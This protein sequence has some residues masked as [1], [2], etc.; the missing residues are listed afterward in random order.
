MS[1]DF[2][3]LKE[4]LVAWP[5]APVE[6]VPVNGVY[7]RIFQIL[8]ASREC[9]FLKERSDLLPLLRQAMLEHRSSLGCETSII[10]LRVP[11]GCGWPGEACWHDFGFYCE[12]SGANCCTVTA[13]RW[14]PGWLPHADQF[15]P[16]EEIYA[17]KQCCPPLSVPIDPCVKDATGFDSYSSAGQREAVR[18]TFFAPAGST[19]VVNL[20]T[21]SGKSLVGYLPSLLGGGEGNFTLFVVPTVA[22]AIDQAQKLRDMYQRTGSSHSGTPLAWYSGVPE[23]DKILI[24]NNIKNGVQ[25]ILFT[26]PE[27]VCGAL[28]WALYE[29]ARR[30]FLKCLVVDE[31]HLVSQWGI[32]FRPDFQALSGIWRGLLDASE[33]NLKTLLMTATLTDETLDT[34]ETLF[35]S[36]E[37]SFQV[38]SAVY[39]RPE[40]RY[41]HY[42]ALSLAEKKGCVLEAVRKGPR[43]LILYVT[44]PKEADEWCGDL[45]REGFSR[46]AS[47]HGNT[48]NKRRIE[49]INQ[50]NTNQLDLIV[51]TSAFGVGMD[52]GDVRMILHAT[53]PENLDRYYQ[54]VGRG[55]RD[56]KAS[57]SLLIYT[58][59]DMDK[60]RGMAFPKVV[61]QGLGRS[62]WLALVQGQVSLG[63][64]LFQMDLATVPAHKHQ[65]S[66]YNRAW[67]MRTLLLMVRAGA[68]RL[69]AQPPPVPSEGDEPL[70]E[71]ELKK[72]FDK[73]V[74]RYLNG[75]HCDEEYW[76]STVAAAKE[77]SLAASQRNFILLRDVLEKETEMGA[78]LE[79][80]YSIC[81]PGFYVSVP[82]SCGGCPHCRN[83][84]RNGIPFSWGEVPPLRG[85]K[86]PPV[87]SWE[88][89]F[90]MAPLH[91]VVV[92]YSRAEEASL[93]A[94]LP[95]V[96]GALVRR[97][98]VREV[99]AS[100]PES[101]QKNPEFT[102]IYRHV[103]ERFIVHGELDED[104]GSD[105][106]TPLRRVTVLYPW[107][108]RPIPEKFFFAM[109]D[110]HLIVAPED[111][112]AGDH[113][114][115]LYT[116]TAN[117]T[118]SLKQLLLRL[119]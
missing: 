3:A 114:H 96:L 60:A 61:T 36:G 74:L 20:P 71:E 97:F 103:P 93:L 118:L 85:V 105:Y 86:V 95:A 30:G 98:G 34:L 84:G 78:A 4:V 31:A 51:A 91:P 53:V 45:K 82:C 106:D 2:T 117:N 40:P 77:N 89:L 5:N 109:K 50:W 113:P 25:P 1:F 73:V 119:N 81:R 75:N 16:L 111:V 9:G 54:E 110:F 101:L 38:V 72:F 22:L 18:G 66:D 65:Q 102:K 49:I 43:P 112:R 69:V 17:G 64:G 83:Q 37:D 94:Q 39:L 32:E 44:E 6:G 92:T 107:G 24:K 57:L 99:V 88:S 10:T 100:S 42:K 67:N 56:K 104:Y 29:A 62:R 23:E 27:A 55:G 47:F 108:T 63:D 7:Q 46:L 68:V 33:N 48:R 70:T 26:S 35:S 59:M 8:S 58:Q 90:P 76:S 79:E 80:L 52:K 115:R 19:V 13:L 41:W 12:T 11:Q 21:G 87:E 15:D 116:D 14:T 28:R